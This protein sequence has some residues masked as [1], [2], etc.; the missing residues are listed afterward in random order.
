M[1]WILECTSFTHIFLLLV[2]TTCLTDTLEG[3]VVR[4]VGGDTLVILDDNKTQHRVRLAR[5]DTPER[6]QPF[7]KQA[8]ENLSRLAANQDTRVKFYKRDR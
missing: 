5:F 7:G 3:K 4:I 8:K 2:S 1:S 6:G